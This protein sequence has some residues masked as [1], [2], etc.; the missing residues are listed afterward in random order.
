MRMR[1]GQSRTKLVSALDLGQAQDFTAWVVT[2]RTSKLLTDNPRT[3]EHE[4][5]VRHIERF[6]PGTA[7][8]E[9]FAAVRERYCLPPLHETMLV[10]D[11]T[12]VGKPV[13]NLLQRTEIP[14]RRK[15]VTITAGTQDGSDGAGGW[16]VPNLDLIGLLQVALQNRVLKIPSGLEYG[17]EL[18]EELQHFKMKPPLASDAMAEVSWRERPHDDLVLALALACWQAERD[19][20]HDEWL[21]I[22]VVPTVFDCRFKLWGF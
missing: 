8:S 20:I 5:A 9:I 19:W 18:V 3:W 22:P 11:Q 12:G 1:V 17:R 13:I 4:T 15:R 6:P 14:C 10:V 2:E 16:L 7:Y 21:D